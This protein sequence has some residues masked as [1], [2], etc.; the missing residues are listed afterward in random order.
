[1]AL[2][3][4]NNQSLSAVTSAGLPSGAIVQVVQG[5]I[6]QTNY[7]TESTDLSDATGFN[8]SITPQSTSNK[9]L[10]MFTGRIDNYAPSSVNNRGSI[11][12]KRGSTIIQRRFVGA[13]IGDGSAN[14]R[15][16]YHAVSLT[17][18][19]SPAT[20]SQVTYQIQLATASTTNRITLVTEAAPNNYHQNFVL[21]EIAG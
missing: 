19:D 2:T 13:Y 10:V 6:P 8:V 5:T 17:A 20:T 18:L 9:I 16:N 1:M 7:Y 4:L 15:N 14:N 11:L 12:I 21:M 3:K